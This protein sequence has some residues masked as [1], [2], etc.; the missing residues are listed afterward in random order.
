MA[1]A[2]GE[3]IGIYAGRILDTPLPQTKTRCA[4]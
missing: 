4:R 1:A 3:A 2:R